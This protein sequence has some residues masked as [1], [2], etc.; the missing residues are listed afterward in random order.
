[1]NQDLAVAEVAQRRGKG[2]EVCFGRIVEPDR[3]V[4]ECEALAVTMSRSS[5]TASE[6]VGGAR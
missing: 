5:R 3:D 2:L 6:T 4:D 1:M